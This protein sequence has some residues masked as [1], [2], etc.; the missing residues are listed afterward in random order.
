MQRWEEIAIKRQ[1]PCARMQHTGLLLQSSVLILWGSK[2]YGKVC[3]DGF[4]IDIDTGN[5][6]GIGQLVRYHTV[7]T[8]I[9]S[10]VRY[11]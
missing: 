5:C 2:S 10:R 1:S 3:E 6:T 8:L 7:H 4:L 9:C 11:I